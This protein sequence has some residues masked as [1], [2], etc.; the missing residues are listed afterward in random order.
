MEENEE[1]KF[2]EAIKIMTEKLINTKNTNNRGFPVCSVFLDENLELIASNVNSRAN[3]KKT[4]FE[5]HA[6]YKCYSDVKLR[7][8]DNIICLVTIPPCNDC[9]DAIF[10]NKNKYEI[11]YFTDEFWDQNNYFKYIK[12]ENKDNNTN[13]KFKKISHKFSIK[14]EFNINYIIMS[15]LGGLLTHKYKPTF[16]RKE[17][18]KLIKEKLCILKNL[19]NN[20]EHFKKT[21]DIPEVLSMIEKVENMNIDDISF[22]DY[23]SR[24]KFKWITD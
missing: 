17:K 8:D 11:Y 9:F 20:N 14:T 16:Q 24:K 23:K 18:L 7:N 21:I 5:N 10:K 19:I 4:N 13:N 22:K 1:I 6:E 12:K 3:G 15:Y 2:E